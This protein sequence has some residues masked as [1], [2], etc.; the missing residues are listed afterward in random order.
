MTT[1]M[2]EEGI[3]RGNIGGCET[4]YPEPFIRHIEMTVRPCRETHGCFRVVLSDFEKSANWSLI[5][6]YRK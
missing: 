1:E 3:W 4:I 6:W 5:A 2:K